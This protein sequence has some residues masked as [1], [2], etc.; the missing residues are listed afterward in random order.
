MFSVYPRKYPHI[1]QDVNG[2]YRKQLTACSQRKGPQVIDLQALS[3]FHRRPV[4]S[5]NVYSCGGPAG[6]RTQI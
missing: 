5:G 2:I 1:V 6:N 4:Y 3:V